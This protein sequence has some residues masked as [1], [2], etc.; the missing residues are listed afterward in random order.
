MNT[1]EI[2]E[3]SLTAPFLSIANVTLDNG[4]TKQ[5]YLNFY[6]GVGEY[7]FVKS[8][9][10]SLFY[11]YGSNSY[12][13]IGLTYG[14]SWELIRVHAIQ[15]IE[16]VEIELNLAKLLFEVEKTT[17]LPLDQFHTWLTPF[18]KCAGE[19]IRFISDGV[20]VNKLDLKFYKC[21]LNFVQGGGFGDCGYSQMNGTDQQITRCKQV[22]VIQSIILSH[23]MRELENSIQNR[24][25]LVFSGQNDLSKWRK[26]GTEL[27]YANGATLPSATQFLNLAAMYSG[28][29][30]PIIHRNYEQKTGLADRSHG[31]YNML[32]TSARNHWCHVVTLDGLNNLYRSETFKKMNLLTF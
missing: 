6:K 21:P 25:Y 18:L 3:L 5:V 26:P 20:I 28:G 4:K 19:V 14:T 23:M 8:L 31:E 16:F 17:I 7:V 1:S 22:D 10:S 13:N 11:P 9:D 12:G 32:P 27:I 30:H 15:T 2:K 29:L 24:G